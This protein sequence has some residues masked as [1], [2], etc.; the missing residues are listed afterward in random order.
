MSKPIRVLQYGV[1][2]IGAAIVR[3]MMEKKGLEIVGAVD[4]D[5]QK[6]G[7]DLGEVAEAGRKLGAPVVDKAA[8]LLDKG[9]DVVVHATSSWLERVEGQL[10]ECLE[11]GAHVVSTCEELSFPFR[12]HPEL[13]KRLDRCAREHNAVLTGVG[14]NPGF[15]MDKLA[16]TL[17]AVCQRVDY[18]EVRRIVDA[19]Q[20]RLPLQRKV[21]ANIT[22][23]EFEARVA[24]GSIKHHGLPE[25]AAQ[26]ANSLGLAVEKFEE[27]IDPVIAKEIVRSKDIEV[28]PGRVAGVRQV[29]SGVT[30]DGKEVVRLELQMYMGAPDSVDAVTIRGVPSLSLEVPGGIHGDL[31]TAA[32]AVNCIPLV[33]EVPPGLR[34][35]GE[36]PMRFFPSSA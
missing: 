33:L 32:I 13:S 18:I 16:L 8:P 29:A 22:M 24:D 35:S 3:L 30:A 9:V 10:T 4:V 5:P 31:A 25:S 21:G 23:E 15:A 28:Q 27:T 1:G 12:K 17:A 26:V 34:T 6:A 14:V 36:I 2:P 20:R 11:R 19:A 7:K